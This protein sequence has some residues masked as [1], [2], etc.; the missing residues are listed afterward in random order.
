[1]RLTAPNRGP[2]TGPGTNSYI[3]GDAKSGY[4]VIDPG[5]NDFDHIGRLWRATGGDIRMIVCTHSHADHSPGAAPLQACAAHQAADPRAA[6]G[7]D[8]AR[9]RALHARSRAARRRATCAGSGLADR[10]TLRVIPTPGH[11]ANHLC[12]VLEEDGAAVFGRPHP[13]R[14]HHRGRSARRRHDALPGFARP[15]RR[16]ARERHRSSSCRPTAT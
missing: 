5:P 10:H 13:Q 1:M 16:P 9:Q 4:I 8:G 2:M 11:A 14:Q 3:V 12:L 7:A 6:L 15:A